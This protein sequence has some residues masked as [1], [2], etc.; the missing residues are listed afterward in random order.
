MQLF[1]HN[2]YNVSIQNW[3]WQK[4]KTI[5]YSL[6]TQTTLSHSTKV[7]LLL[8]NVS[9]FFSKSNLKNETLSDFIAGHHGGSHNGTAAT[10]G[11]TRPWS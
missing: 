2:M 6:D 11:W 1:T 7:Y 8:I 10:R 3:E 5:N 4:E 9:F